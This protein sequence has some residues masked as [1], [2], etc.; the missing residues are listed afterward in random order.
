MA[1]EVLIDVAVEVLIG[2]AV[3]VLIGMAVY[4]EVDDQARDL[5]V[6]MLVV[7]LEASS[8]TVV[9][10]PEIVESDLGE[11]ISHADGCLVGGW[12]RS[13]SCNIPHLQ[14]INIHS[15]P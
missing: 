5:V 10:M 12:E 13:T 3:E 8:V 7:D 14:R 4:V 9:G 1:A 11:R 2:V 6:G 15:R